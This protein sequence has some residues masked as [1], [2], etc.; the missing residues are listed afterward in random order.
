MFLN[1]LGCKL[2]FGPSVLT[3]KSLVKTSL[4]NCGF[5]FMSFGSDAIISFFGKYK[6][7]GIRIRTSLSFVL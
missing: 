6:I 2:I 7:I 3:P 1:S 4:I 5:S